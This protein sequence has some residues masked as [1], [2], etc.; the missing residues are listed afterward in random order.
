MAAVVDVRGRSFFADLTEALAQLE[1]D[2]IDPRIVFLEASDEA[3][4][5][6]FE[7]V[8]RP[9]PLQGT[10]G[11]STASPPSA[12][13]WRDLRADAD[14][15][16]DTSDLNVHE[17]RAK[18]V[19][20]VRRHGRTGPARDAGVVRL[21]VRPAG[22]RRPRGGLP[23]PAQPALGARAAAAD[24]PRPGGQRLRAAAARREGVPRRA[25]PS[26]LERSLGGLLREGKRFVTVAVGCTGGKHR[27]V[28]MAE[29][30]RRRL[31]RPRHRV[32]VVH[33]DL[34]RGVNVPRARRGTTRTVV[35]L[36]GGHGLA[37]SLS[38]LRRVT[39]G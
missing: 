3:L 25:T 28:A 18:V 9:H 31:A 38:A 10:G 39:S 5:R 36:G 33:R 35:A 16:I 22:R 8:R 12:S 26:V 20:R 13:C 19:Q 37:A 6:R 30:L 2:G 32:P 23:V 14:L 7:A 27:R 15:V 24:R 4:V 21:Q 11:S 17:L 29:E 1:T 34:G